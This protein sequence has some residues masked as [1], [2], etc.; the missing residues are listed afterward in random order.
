[1]RPIKCSDTLGAYAKANEFCQSCGVP[2]ALRA[3]Q[4][5]HIIRFG[6]SDELCN[7]LALCWRCHDWHHSYAKLSL[8]Q[9]LS[10]KKLRDPANWDPERL[11]EL[12]LKNLPTLEPIPSVLLAEWGRW[13]P[14]EEMEVPW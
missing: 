14:A 12:Y 10:I 4:L 7:L 3:R 11:K 8:A 13:R 5:H 6:R 1:M 2:P 9:V